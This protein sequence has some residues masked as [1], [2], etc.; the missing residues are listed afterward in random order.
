MDG[1]HDLGGREGYGNVDVDED[2]EQFHEPWE[3]RVRGMVNA[4]SR[5]DDW[6]LDWFRHCRELIMPSDYLTRP[7]FDQWIQTYGAMMVNSGVATVEELATGRASGEGVDLPP[8]MRA[9]QVAHV[10][11]GAKRFDGEI[12][13]EP[14]FGVD[15]PVRCLVHG[16]PGHTRLP[17]YVR[18]RR[19]IVHAHHGA[20]VFPDANARG[21][22]YFEHLYTVAFEA[23]ELWGEQGG[24]GDRVLVNLWESYLDPR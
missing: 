17:G 19:G 20:H 22:K 23:R 15:D 12:E 1:V 16:H 6:T 3:A 13:A 8:P 21:D 10:Q 18:G 4:M 2:E 5:A 11:T 14:R 24:G 9:E 7:Y